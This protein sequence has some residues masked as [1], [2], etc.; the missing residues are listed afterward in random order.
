MLQRLNSQLAGGAP[1]SADQKALGSFWNMA[2]LG[3]MNPGDCPP[4]HP[5]AHTKTP[6]K[7]DQIRVGIFSSA[8]PARTKVHKRSDTR[9]AWSFQTDARV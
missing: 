1:D 5:S 8:H 9:K 7:E 6:E 3:Y 4:L 2:Q